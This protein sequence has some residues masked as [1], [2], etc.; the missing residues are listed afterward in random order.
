MRSSV[1]EVLQEYVEQVESLINYV[2]HSRTL[3]DV[4]D[5]LAIA[6]SANE[7]LT[8]LTDLVEELEEADDEGEY[9]SDEY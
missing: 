9:N 2:S 5:G 4:A 8:A 1:I 7:L 3:N 6:D